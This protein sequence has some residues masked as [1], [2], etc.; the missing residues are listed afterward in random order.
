MPEP[1][2][3]SGSEKGSVASPSRTVIVT[4]AGLTASAARVTVE[5]ILVRGLTRGGR[6]SEQRRRRGRCVRRPGSSDWWPTWP[7]RS[8][9]SRR[10]WRSARPRTGRPSSRPSVA[11]TAAAAGREVARTSAAASAAASPG[12]TTRFVALP[13]ACRTSCGCHLGCRKARCCKDR[14]RSHFLGSV[15]RDRRG[16]K[17]GQGPVKKRTRRAA[18]QRKPG[19][20]CPGVLV[21]ATRPLCISTMERTIDSPSPEPAARDSF[22]SAPR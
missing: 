7:C 14:S 2:P 17:Q 1:T 9:P 22:A 20:P 16:F 4:T 19:C 13:G 3:V 11:W 15:K 5:R 8:G 12:R 6:R 21:I 10:R 18:A